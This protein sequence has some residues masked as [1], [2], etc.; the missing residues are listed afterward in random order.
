VEL[1]EFEA[2]FLPK[3][4]RLAKLKF[5]PHDSWYQELVFGKAL[6]EMEKEV[7]NQELVT[8]GTNLKEFEG[9]MKE[10]LK[11]VKGRTIELDLMKE[12]LKGQVA[13]AL[14][15]SVD[16]LQGVLNTSVGTLTERDN[17]LDAV[18]TTLKEQIE[19]FKGELVI[20]K[21]ALGNDVLAAIP[22]LKVNSFKPKEF[23]GSTDEKQ[24][25]ATIGTWD[26][27]QKEFKGQFYPEYV[28]DKAQ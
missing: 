20:C 5:Q 13:E 10:R 2:K 22:K 6:I 1:G 15:T 21:V 8:V 4:A 12:Q 7:N 27:F 9:G 16:A 14:D 25:R 24:G 23:K 28:E 26:E 18:V 11:V 19:D 3:V 17:T